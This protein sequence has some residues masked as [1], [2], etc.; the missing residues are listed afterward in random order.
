MKI[1]TRSF[2]LKGTAVPLTPCVPE[3]PLNPK[4]SFFLTFSHEVS[5]AA[6][7][8]DVSDYGLFASGWSN[9]NNDS[10][11]QQPSLEERCHSVLQHG[12][13]L[14]E[15]G[16]EPIPVMVIRRVDGNVVAAGFHSDVPSATGVHGKK[17]APRSFY[18]LIV[19]NWRD[20]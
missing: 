14:G 18:V 8:F 15:P 17:T 11:V 12:C 19:R 16:R 7:Q 20:Y 5:F 10:S 3:P 9:Q 2:Y 1:T 13:L 6:S 4:L